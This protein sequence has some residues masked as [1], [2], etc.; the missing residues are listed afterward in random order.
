MISSLLNLF[1]CSGQEKKMTD[2]KTDEMQKIFDDF[3]KR[4]IYKVLTVDIIKNIKDENLEQAIIDN[5]Q[6]K[7]KKDFSNEE[8]VVR[9][10]SEGQKAIY[11]TWIL[12]AEV[13]NGGFNQFYF[14]SS[15]QLADLGQD[16]FKTIGAIQFASLVGRADSIYD[17]TKEDLEKYNDGTIESFS[18]SYD[19]NPLNDLDDKFYKL[20][21]DEPLNQ[22][23]IKYIRD[24]IKEFVTE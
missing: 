17:A 20:Y 13:N 8:E 15:G 10:L 6:T 2:G 22:I 3:E 16:A 23:K 19:K 7:F 1:G 21:K 12:E 24:N 11:V 9:S 18:K 4:P 14:N 5:I